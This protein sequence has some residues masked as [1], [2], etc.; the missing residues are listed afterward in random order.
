MRDDHMDGFERYVVHVGNEDLAVSIGGQGPPV[1]LLHGFPQTHIAW[2]LVA[3]S[4]ANAFTVVCVDLPGYGDSPAP[5]TDYAAYAKRATGLAMV[6]LMRQLGWDRFSL[7]GHD[8][9]GLV[10]FRAALDHPDVIT[11]LA[12]LDILPTNDMWS[13]LAGTAG[14]FAFHLYLLAQPN[15]L[16]ERLLAAAPRDF[17]G[18]FLD[19]WTSVPNAIPQSVRDVYLAASSRS[20]SIRAICNDYRASAFIDGEHDDH[21]RGQG[22]KLEMPVLAMWQDPGD[23]PLPFDPEKIWSSWASDLRTEALPCGH[24]LPEECPREVAAGVAS[25]LALS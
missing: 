1:L 15:D 17:F 5:G 12:V 25:L 16:P 21:D 6:R 9:G 2:R 7:V 24:F 22:N 23:Q 14:V 11:H 10:G 4:L 19:V 18:H 3:P 13:S 20:E 8:R